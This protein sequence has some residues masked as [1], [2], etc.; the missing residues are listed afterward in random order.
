MEGHI[1]IVFLFGVIPIGLFAMIFAI[2]FL[3]NRERMAMIERGITPPEERKKQ[4]VDPSR[5]L[6]NGLIFLGAGIGLLLAMVI[7]KAMNAEE[8]ERN[9]IYFGTIAIFGGLGMLGAYFYER[10]N[11]PADE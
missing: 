4:E 5:T 10:K 8:G 2:R 11:P 7:S 3:Q 1:A 6:K 9:A